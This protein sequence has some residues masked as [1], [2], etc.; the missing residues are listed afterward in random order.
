[1]Q[2]TAVLAQA[3]QELQIAVRKAPAAKKD[4]LRRA[5]SQMVER[6]DRASRARTKQEARGEALSNYDDS[7]GLQGY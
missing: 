7:L 2:A 4:K 5:A 1:V 6:K 3:E